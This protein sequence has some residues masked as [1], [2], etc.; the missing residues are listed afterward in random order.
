[1]HVMIPYSSNMEASKHML[2]EIGGVFE[3]A[4]TKGILALDIIFVLR[5]ITNLNRINYFLITLF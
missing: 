1:M 2:L 5:D 4:L 3:P